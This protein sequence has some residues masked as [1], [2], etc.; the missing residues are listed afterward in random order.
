M[1][2]LLAGE[3]SDSESRGDC[4]PCEKQICI[5]RGHCSWLVEGFTARE[6]PV[7]CLP[8]YVL[9]LCVTPL[10]QLISSLGGLGVF[11]G[12]VSGG[13]LALIV[14]FVCI[15]TVIPGCPGHNS[16]KQR[17]MR[18]HLARIEALEQHRR[19]SGVFLGSHTNRPQPHGPSPPMPPMPPHGLDALMQLSHRSRA[20]TVSSSEPSPWMAHQ[21]QNHYAMITP[22]TSTRLTEH[23]LGIHVH[24]VY[25]KGDNSFQRPWQLSCEPP[26]VAVALVD[27][28]A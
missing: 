23:D 27:G 6:C 2:K 12:L 20:R 22:H 14:L 4:Q 17:K 8:G 7:I 26:E 21:Y 9:P 19:H 10:E 5:A 25:L 15:C 13:V 24:R 1:I 11:I 18:Q 16:N 28:P 3:Y